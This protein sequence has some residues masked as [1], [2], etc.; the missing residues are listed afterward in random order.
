L[1]SQHG[2]FCTPWL[3]STRK[4]RPGSSRSTP[5]S[6]YSPRKRP[7]IIPRFT[8]HQ[9]NNIGVYADRLHGANV[10]MRRVLIALPEVC[11]VRDLLYI[12]GRTWAPSFS[13]NTAGLSVFESLSAGSSYRCRK[14]PPQVESREHL[15][16]WMCKLHNEVN[17]RLGKPAFNC[18]LVRSR[19]QE[20]DCEISHACSL[21]GK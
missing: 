13:I 2:H 10:S 3:R 8:H 18:N 7:M 5:S 19:W 15:E 4:G 20:L 9:F 11:Q 6:W 14:D 12:R 17:S 1:V 21:T 16:Q